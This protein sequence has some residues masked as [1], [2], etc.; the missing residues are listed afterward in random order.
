MINNTFIHIIPVDC[1]KQFAREIPKLDAKI[2]KKGNY[3]NSFNNNYPSLLF[4]CLKVSRTIDNHWVN[5]WGRF[6]LI[7]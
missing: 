6:F 5:H 1:K 4:I 7:S 2:T 3:Y